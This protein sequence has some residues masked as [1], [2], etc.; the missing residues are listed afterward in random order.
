MF[1][2]RFLPRRVFTCI[3]IAALEAKH[4]PAET[5]DINKFKKLLLSQFNYS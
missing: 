3:L 1:T 4:T 5:E 2:T